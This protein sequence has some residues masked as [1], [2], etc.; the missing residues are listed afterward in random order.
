MEFKTVDEDSSSKD[1][2]YTI[3][4]NYSI[5]K[6][7]E[8]EINKL[9]ATKNV[10][11]SI[12][13]INIKNIV[14]KEERVQEEKNES[15][16][17]FED[18]INYYLE[19]YNKLAQDFSIDELRGVLP[20]RK[21][22]NFKNIIFRL[23]A[24]SIK[25]IKEISEWILSDDGLNS[26]ELAELKDIIAHENRKIASLNVILNE[27]EDEIESKDVHNDLILLPTMNGNIRII[28][29]L[30]HV[31]REY[32]YEVLELIDS[33]VNG[34]FKRVRRF[35]TSDSLCEVRGS[36]TRVIFSRVGRNTYVLVSAFIKKVGKDNKYMDFLSQKISAYQKL[37]DFIKNSIEDSEFRRENDFYVDCLYKELEG[38]QTNK[39]Y[40][41]ED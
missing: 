18:E 13:D 19:D 6:Y 36:K 34:T 12:K 32:Y 35:V 41:K 17:D 39:K 25:S 3:E 15:S 33:I 14:V 31:P 1:L 16:D 29:D 26:I 27:K 11:S 8:K 4:Q 21:S 2:L 37:E 40:V 30:K 7:A 24:D 5:A 38:R 22:Y 20:S 10:R 28:D 9:K 23:Y